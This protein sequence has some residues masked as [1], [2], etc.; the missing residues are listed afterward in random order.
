MM[1]RRDIQKRIVFVDLD[2]M[3]PSDHL[4]RRIDEAIDFGFIYEISE[5]YYSKL[6]RGS[7]D[8]VTLVKML[9]IGYL[10]GIKSERRLEQEVRLNSAYRWFCGLEL[11]EPVPDHSV[12]SQNRRRR[13][14][15]GK[16]FREIFNAIVA[17]CME[18]G[19]ITGG[20]VVSDGTF[21]PANVAWGSRD[22]S[23]KAIEKSA[24][25]YLEE[26]DRE[27]QNTP[28]YKPPERAV[29]ERNIVKSATDRDAG[30]IS[31]ANKKGIGYVAEISVDTAFGLVTGVDVVPANRRESDIILRHLKRQIEENGIPIKNL[32]LDA[33]YDVGAVHRGLE[34]L[35]I[36]GYVSLRGYHNCP[37]K[38]GFGYLPAEDVFVCP[39]GRHLAFRR[40]VYKK[41][42]CNYFRAYEADREGCK[43]CPDW[44]TCSPDNGRCRIHA[45]SFYPSYYANQQR[46]T[47][48][49]YK[50]M[51]RL[52]SIW[53]E[54]TFSVLK[55]ERNMS[56]ARKRGIS[57]M[58]EE[59]LMAAS[60]LNLKR[61]ANVICIAFLETASAL[62]L[63][64]YS[65]VL[66]NML[67][68]VA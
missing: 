36:T 38:K 59:C 21:I 31:H 57:K 63:R 39:R 25:S 65:S 33:G 28:G 7:V 51:K 4:L 52:R 32:A 66:V 8:P 11:D 5:P 10:Y 58:A 14:S 9:L 2:A 54:G 44:P 68:V 27:L 53:S 23:V 22:D 24:V 26:L 29:E 60:A 41:R 45:S 46:N 55:R 67:V 37:I 40:L 1:K 12:F 35:G 19:L 43:G 62:L 42:N 30:Y 50:R 64:R 47:T 49:E 34:L 48:P 6:G 16:V 56:R 61:M 3:M 20:D 15:D 18:K 17:Q 13:F